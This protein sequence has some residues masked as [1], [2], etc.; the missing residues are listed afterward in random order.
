MSEGFEPVD[1]A[2]V[3][4]G[5]SGLACAFWAK[6]RGRSVALFEASDTVGGSIKTLRLGRYI[7]DGGPQ[8]FSVSEA[9]AQLV[10]DAELDR[11]MLPALPSASTPYIY[12]HGRLVPAPSSPQT[13]VA[14]P[15]LTPFAKLRVLGEL[16]V[17]KSEAVDESVASFVTRRAGREV[18]DAIVTP[19]VAG[20]FAGDAEKLSV[21]S[22]FP[23]LAELERDHGS[24]V[25]GALKKWSDRAHAREAAWSGRARSTDVASDSGVRS[26]RRPV[27]FRGG[28]DLLPRSLAAHLGADFTVTAP[29]KAMWQ[30]GQWMELL[31]GGQTNARVIAKSIVLATPART[32]A[33]LLEPLESKAAVALRAIEHPTVVQI[34]MAY[35]RN[36]VGVQLDGFGFLASRREELKILGCVWNSA[37]FPD[38]CPPE[39]VLVTAFMG[40]ATDGAVAQQSDEEL[41]RA[42]H[43]D[44]QRVLKIEAAAPHVVAG[45]R[46]H[47]AIPQYNV[48]HA[49]RIRIIEE[50]VA[51][52]PEVRLCGNYLRGPSVS[53][54]I[55]LAHEISSAL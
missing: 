38:R 53:D 54:C 37:M 34:S 49:Q 14:T 1:V 42:A 2:V 33:D 5:I 18:L 43:M 35:P 4:G 3:G 52:L 44:L 13:L 16:F 26:H 6:K 55:K 27:A 47:E 36:A 11:L 40:G 12:H 51:R 22:A 19:F 9:F 21:R 17:D 23:M 46:W 41:A 48:G 25:R 7:A 39:E 50:C 10:E 32:T 15:L 20:T 29:V 24:V 45:F 28:N 31:V 30:R 8:S